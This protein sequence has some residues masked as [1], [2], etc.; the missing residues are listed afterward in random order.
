[1]TAWRVLGSY[2][3]SKAPI[4][5]AAMRRMKRDIEVNRKDLGEDV[6]INQV[7]A[8][9]AEPG[10][11]G[12]DGSESRG[13]RSAASSFRRSIARKMRPS[14]GQSPGPERPS[15]SF[16]C[17]DGG[18]AESGGGGEDGGTPRRDH[19][20]GSF[21]R[22]SINS[23]QS[24]A[25]VEPE[26]RGVL[27]ASASPAAL[28]RAAA[29]PS[30]PEATADASFET[31]K[32]E[33]AR[34]E[35]AAQKASESAQQLADE[36]AAEEAVTAAEA[37]ATRLAAEARQAAARAEAL[38]DSLA[39][40]ATRDRRGSMGP[41]EAAALEA[42]LAKIRRFSAATSDGE[43]TDS[44]TTAPSAPAQA[45]IDIAAVA[46]TACERAEVPPERLLT[47]ED[48]D[49]AITEAPSATNTVEAST[50][51]SNPTPT[52]SPT[53]PKP[54]SPGRKSPGG[55]RATFVLAPPPTAEA[56]LRALMH[57]RGLQHADVLRALASIA[58]RD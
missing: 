34:L 24:R 3:E 21:R 49:A 22:P 20:G 15:C 23:R 51:S 56:A 42:R 55:I 52:F 47:M 18:G 4:T 16:A 2:P 8:F 7:K 44:A 53:P 40:P 32:G 38:D 31:A 14:C 46:S 1:M 33:A 57:E 30:D 10:D 37:E 5:R 6:T 26:P 27:S 13:A 35:A 43:A 9:H 11:G 48:A 36:G 25:S 29:P 45:P 28:R 19:R 41:E 58:E 17:E 39:S 54:R 12:A 50:S